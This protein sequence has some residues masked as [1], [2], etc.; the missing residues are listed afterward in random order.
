VDKKEDIEPNE[1]EV[2][3]SQTSSAY[4]LVP[5]EQIIS[6]CWPDRR[7]PRAVQLSSQISRANEARGSQDFKAPQPLDTRATTAQS[8]AVAQAPHRPVS[9]SPSLD[10]YDDIQ[11]SQRDERRQRVGKAK[12]KS[13]TPMRRRG[14]KALMYLGPIAHT[15]SSTAPAFSSQERV[16]ET[17]QA[18]PSSEASPHD[19][20]GKEQTADEALRVVGAPIPIGE[21]L[22]QP[23]RMPRQ[24]GQRQAAAGHPGAPSAGS[25]GPEPAQGIAEAQYARRAGEPVMI[26][27]WCCRTA[28]YRNRVHDVQQTR[29]DLRREGPQHTAIADESEPIISKEETLSLIR[30]EFGEHGLNLS[31]V[32]SMLSHY[33]YLRPLPSARKVRAFMHFCLGDHFGRDQTQRVAA[34]HQEVVRSAQPQRMPLAVASAGQGK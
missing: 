30:L 6:T 13:R 9:T 27:V 10:L 22:P 12:E 25:C 26:A 8:S 18:L 14:R 3:L 33:S 29:Y 23:K 32:Q 2:S 19:A 34:C 15:A 11:V 31:L 7:E 28:Q 17:Q 5:S 20:T 1:P 24:K 4:E 16:D 21:P